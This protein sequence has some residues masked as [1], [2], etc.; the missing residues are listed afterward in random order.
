[1]DFKLTEVRSVSEFD[2]IWPV[3]FQ[4]YRTP[5]NVLSKFFNPVHTTLE[6]A[7]D[8]SKARHVKMWGENEGCHWVKVTE[9][10]KVVGAACWI[11]RL[12]QPSYPTNNTP[13]NAYWHIEGSDEK[14][15]TERLISGIRN[16]VSEKVRIAHIGK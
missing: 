11:F 16:F 13:F 7:I 9:A 10:G 4:T 3:H 1:M 5:Y 6:A 15:F 12:D 14:A 2:E 8:A